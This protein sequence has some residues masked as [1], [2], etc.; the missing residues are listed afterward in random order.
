MRTIALEEHFAT[1]A[2]MDGPERKLR[3]RAEKIGG[4]LTNLV[5]ALLDVGDGRIAAMDSAGSTYRLCR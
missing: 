3:E 4:R 2:F 5:A 1:Q